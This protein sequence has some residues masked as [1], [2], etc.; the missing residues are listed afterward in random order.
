[1]SV[2]FYKVNAAIMSIMNTF[3]FPDR[4]IEYTLYVEVFRPQFCGTVLVATHY[5][6]LSTLV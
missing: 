5:P 3:L 1:M 4:N 2:S 6:I